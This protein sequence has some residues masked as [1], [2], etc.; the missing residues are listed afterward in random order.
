MPRRTS[1]NQLLGL[2]VHGGA[3]SLLDLAGGLVGY[4]NPS[5]H[6]LRQRALVL[7]AASALYDARRDGDPSNAHPQLVIDG[8][9]R[10]YPTIPTRGW[11]SIGRVALREPAPE[12][13]RIAQAA[14]RALAGRYASTTEAEALVAAL[15]AERVRPDL[16]P[17][18]AG[19][20][21]AALQ[22]RRQRAALDAVER[23]AWAGARL[24]AL[25]AGVDRARVADRLRA[26]ADEIDGSVTG[27]GAASAGA[28]ASMEPAGR[29]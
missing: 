7:A 23:A 29:A 9:R 27:Q 18:E 13:L 4:A 15:C 3:A 14:N 24:A 25:R 5:Q 6:T 21:L 12:V 1:I 10:A 22:A 17:Q 16:D 20:R 26:L 11:V 2:P 19:V 8:A 28:L